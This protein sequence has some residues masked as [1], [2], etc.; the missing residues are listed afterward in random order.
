MKKID[1]FILGAQ[2]CGTTSLFYYIEDHPHI[3]MSD[4][5]EVVYFS[6]DETYAKGESY[7]NQFFHQCNKA[8]KL[9]T[10]DVRLLTSTRAPQRVHAYNPNARLIVCLRDPV[11]RA[12]SA[13]WMAI[14][15]GWEYSRITFEEAMNRELNSD[16]E[17]DENLPENA[18]HRHYIRNGLYYT[19]MQKWLQ[20]FGEDNIMLI[21]DDSLKENATKVL[22]DIFTF[23]GVD[24]DFEPDTTK[25]YNTVANPRFSFINTFIAG[26]KQ[27]RATLGRIIPKTFKRKITRPLVKKIYNW[28]NVPSDYPAEL[29]VETKNKL[30]AIFRNDLDQL[31]KKYGI[32]L[33]QRNYTHSN[34]W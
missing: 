25:K 3:C 17:A 2:K 19:Q 18:F 26:N 13:Y 22:K 24:P 6:R 28:N 33:F 8:E 9:G 30:E 10:A 31:Y 15:N 4:P 21:R 20:Y 11:E 14:R 7:L 34:W 23:I 32:D 16:H 29:D 1:F 12:F 27:L 5:K